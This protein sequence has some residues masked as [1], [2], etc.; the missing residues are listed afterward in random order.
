[1]TY[2]STSS[3]NGSCW[4]QYYSISIL[5]ESK[6]KFWT[7]IEVVI[8]VKKIANQ[9]YGRLPA[10]EEEGIPLDILLVYL[11]GLYNLVIEG[12]YVIII[13]NA[14]TMIDPTTGWFE[15]VQYSYKQATTIV[16]LL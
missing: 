4:R 8:F 7:H 16:N 2:I 9:K 3:R 5:A 11:I 15:I 1:M 6:G 14:L 12:Q 10:K 13:I